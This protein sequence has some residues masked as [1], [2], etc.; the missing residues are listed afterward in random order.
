[1][2]DSKPSGYMLDRHR[3]LAIAIFL[4]ILFLVLMTLFYLKADEVTKNP[5]KIC[6]DSIGESFV[7]YSLDNSYNPITF[8]SENN[9][10]E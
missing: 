8:F 2:E 6:A 7:C 4:L 10:G 3:F 9:T 5:C 1:M